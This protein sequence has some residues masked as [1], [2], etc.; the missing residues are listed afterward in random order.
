[1]HECTGSP[2]FEHISWEL[3]PSG[4]SLGE[5]NV[6]Q[7]EATKVLRVVRPCTGA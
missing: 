4:D 2:T 5:I 6:Q 1:M 3:P 7:V